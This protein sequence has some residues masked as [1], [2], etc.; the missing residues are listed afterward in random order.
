MAETKTTTTP[1]RPA[2]SAAATTATKTAAKPAQKPA[3]TTKT[4]KAVEEAPATPES[5]KVQVNL[6]YTGDTKKYA[7]FEPPADS[8][9]VGTFYAPLGTDEVKVLLILPP[10][11]VEA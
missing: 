9:C 1:R 6:V 5:V 11:V 7:K 2:R 10:E 4:T 3:A 8:G